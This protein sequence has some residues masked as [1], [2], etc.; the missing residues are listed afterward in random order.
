MHFSIRSAV[1][2]MAAASC[3]SS[4]FA[5]K[6]DAKPKP[7]FVFILTDDQDERMDSLA[8]MPLVQDLL[9]KEGTHFTKH[10]AHLAWCCPSRASLWTGQHAHNHNVTAVEPPG[11]GWPKIQEIGRW[12]N[13]L[14]V[15]MQKAGYNT[16]YSGKLYNNHTVDNYGAHGKHVAGWTESDFLLDPY[17]YTFIDSTFQHNRGNLHDKPTKVKGYSTSIITDNTLRYIDDA[18]KAKKPFL[19]IAAPVAPHVSI[20]NP[21]GAIPVPEEKYDGKLSNLKVPRAP[22][23]N[24]DEKS[25]VLHISDIAKV[26]NEEEIKTWDE[27]YQKRAESLLS[28][29][30]MV[31]EV[32]KKL[33]KQG[34]LDNTYIIYS[35]DN[36]YHI[37]HHRMSPGKKCAYEEDINVP[38]IIRGPGIA[39]GKETNLVTAHIDLAPTIM[40][41]AGLGG[42][43]RKH[44]FDG[45]GLE[46]PLEKDED[47]ENAKKERGEHVNVEL[48]GT[49]M[50]EGFIF[51]AIKAIQSYK[52]LRI[53]G[54]KYDLMYSVW[55][56][57]SA[58]ELYDMT[59]DKFQMNN[60]YPKSLQDK[61]SPKQ[62]KKKAPKEDKK[63]PL[64]DNKK[65]PRASLEK[66]QKAGELL[67]RPLQQV[68]N[69]LDAVLL[70]QKSCKE[71]ECRKP[72]KQ[73][74]PN[75]R[76]KNLQDAL[77]KQYD[78]QYEKYPKVKF[79]RCLATPVYRPQIEGPQWGDVKHKRNV[80][81]RD[82]D[83][84]DVDAGDGGMPEID[85]GQ[86]EDW[87][88]WA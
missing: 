68:L 46:L 61:K 27:L 56:N 12:N 35:S 8:H 11:G 30:D 45:Q 84:G 79:E 32:V 64:K 77:D 18:V 1:A 24:P 76:V 66:K 26:T 78:R 82:L 86:D 33:E 25:G 23:F 80:D 60:L 51:P 54:P 52:A 50:Q 88:D 62:R 13:Y 69:R 70:V 34:I 53:Q 44:K 47:F 67:G 49:Y 55:C 21:R 9:M 20:R 14:P 7:N 85:M 36:G 87:E 39:K 65:E 4:V 63:S 75:G 59:N 74:H 22:N 6:E 19:A 15:W 72:W 37:G 40:N 71:D 83:V 3:I 48:W 41:L 73:L 17:T 31:G 2:L 81:M 42:E 29:D 16:Y 10:Y 5:K 43:N 57:Q 58:H 28:V 38:L